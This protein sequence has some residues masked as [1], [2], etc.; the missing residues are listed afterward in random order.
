M[1]VSGDNDYNRNKNNMI[2]YKCRLLT[3]QII[4]AVVFRVGFFFSSKLL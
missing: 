4:I 3:T 2:K 1:V